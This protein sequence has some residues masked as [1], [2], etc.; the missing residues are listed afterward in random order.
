[1]GVR[2]L[3]GDVDLAPE[4][5]GPDGRAQFRLQD[6]ERNISVVLHIS[7]EVDPRHTAFAEFRLDVIAALQGRVQAGDCIEVHGCYLAGRSTF[8]RLCASVA[9]HDRSRTHDA[10]HRS[11]PATDTD[12]SG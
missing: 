7:R 8:L 9:H 10:H 3:R 11:A 5:L 1:M 12:A 2:E 4:P 6:L